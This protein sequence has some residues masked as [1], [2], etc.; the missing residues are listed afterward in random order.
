M[1]FLVALGAGV[2]TATAASPPNQ[3]IVLGSETPSAAAALIAL[4]TFNVPT[5]SYSTATSTAFATIP[6]TDALGNAN[7]SIIVLGSGVIDFSPAQWS[8]LYAYQ[9]ANNVRLVSLYDVPGLGASATYTAGSTT[10]FTTN[11]FSLSPNST[12]AT[13]AA[14]LPTSYSITFNT[15]G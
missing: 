5:I 15:V 13:T 3:V 4:Q 11:T 12:I 10:S 1:K 9:N 7:F 8:Q 6:L 2:A 14:G